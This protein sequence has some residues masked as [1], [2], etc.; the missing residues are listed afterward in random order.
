MTKLSAA[1]TRFVPEDGIHDSGQGK[2]DSPEVD[3]E[4]PVVLQSD[5]SHIPCDP[6]VQTSVVS[7]ETRM[8][9][10]IF[11]SMVDD[12]PQRRRLPDPRSLLYRTPLVDAL[13]RS[14][15]PDD[16]GVLE[17]RGL[18][19]MCTPQSGSEVFCPFGSVS[20]PRGIS[21]V[22]GLIDLLQTAPRSVLLVI[23]VDFADSLPGTVQRGHQRMCLRPHDGG[24]I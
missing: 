9:P 14:A 12:R 19:K 3:V 18:R 1:E 17:I 10:E 6:P 21:L 23:P 11:Y 8:Y 2:D 15:R 13:Q 7:W 16:A 24:P 4:H 20:P 5:A 22:P